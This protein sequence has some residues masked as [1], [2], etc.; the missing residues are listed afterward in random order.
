[1]NRIRGSSFS[2]RAPLL[3]LSFPPPRPRCEPL[4]CRA[5][6]SRGSLASCSASSAEE[7][8][9]R[10]NCDGRSWEGTDSVLRSCL[11]LA[12]LGDYNAAGILTS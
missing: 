1:M 9:R 6:S 2:L 5:V 7:G 11:F 3:S 12:G 4:L 10:H 8:N